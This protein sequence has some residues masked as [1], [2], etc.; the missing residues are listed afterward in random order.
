MR[1]T[2]TLEDDKPIRAG[3][4]LFYH[5]DQK[6]NQYKLLMINSRNKYEDFGGQ[7][8]EVD[9]DYLDTVSREVEEES[10][11]II[12]KDYIRDKI[13]NLEPIYIKHCK[14]ILYCVE[15]DAYYNPII[16]GDHEVVDDINRTVEWISY[17]DFKSDDFKK[18]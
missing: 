7:T 8:D 15:A 5:H 17:D 16:F 2:F 11:G 6:T 14:Y 18:N 1:P 4:I 9:K 3:G 12:P 10:N 13:K